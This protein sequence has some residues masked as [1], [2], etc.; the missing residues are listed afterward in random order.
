MIF[1]PNDSL[2]S[3]TLLR[4]YIKLARDVWFCI[5][6]REFVNKLEMSRLLY[7][8]SSGISLSEESAPMLKNLWLNP[9]SF[10]LL[11]LYFFDLM[12]PHLCLCRLDIQGRYF[13]LYLSMKMK[14]TSFERGS[15]SLLLNERKFCKYK[16]FIYKLVFF[17]SP[18]CMS[19]ESI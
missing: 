8:L 4:A 2:Y 9:P 17:T 5:L 14:C 3:F 6:Y 13:P 10:I 15:T 18:L 16:T 11:E 12:A 7:S 19:W 1:N